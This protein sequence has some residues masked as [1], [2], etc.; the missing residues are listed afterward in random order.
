MNKIL[1]LSTSELSSLIKEKKIT[2]EELVC[3]TLS[4]IKTND[5]KINSIITLLEDSSIQKAKDFDKKN[6]KNEIN[7]N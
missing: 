4:H 2:S 7:Q 3:E 1:N 6:Y 5:K